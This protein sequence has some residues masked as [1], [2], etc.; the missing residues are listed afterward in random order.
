LLLLVCN[1]SAD[2]VHCALHFAPRS[3]V[4]TACPEHARPAVIAA[5]TAVLVV[6][7]AAPPARRNREPKRPAKAEGKIKGRSTKVCATPV[8]TGRGRGTRHQRHRAAIN[9]TALS[10]LTNPRAS[11]ACAC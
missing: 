8:C 4:Q 11:F 6:R 9:V 5:F 10:A 7:A 3:I 1:A 2:S